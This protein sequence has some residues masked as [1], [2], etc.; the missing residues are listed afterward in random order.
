MAHKF[1]QQMKNVQENMLQAKSYREEMTTCTHHSMTELITKA[2]VVTQN[3]E[4][5]NNIDVQTEKN[6]YLDMNQLD[7][8][9]KA[10]K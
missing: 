7:S 9:D 3:H 5:G 6:A 8:Y 2:L 10:K 1:K 4:K